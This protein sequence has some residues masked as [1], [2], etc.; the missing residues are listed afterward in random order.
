MRVQN[1]PLC[2]KE[3][4]AV[5]VAE[6]EFAERLLMEG[7]NYEFRCYHASPTIEELFTDFDALQMNAGESYHR[8]DVSPRASFD[9]SSYDEKEYLRQKA[10]EVARRSQIFSDAPFLFAPTHVGY[11]I[12]AIVTGS[13]TDDGCVGAKLL[14]YVAANSSMNTKA[15]L[16]CFCKSVQEVVLYLV[17]CPCMD[18]RPTCGRAGEI[19]AERA[20][21]LRRVLGEVASVRLLRKLESS[22]SGSSVYLKRSRFETDFTPP[23]QV[24]ARTFVRVSPSNGFC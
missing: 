22:R 8:G 23:R 11:A 15:E 16:H 10:L 7:L 13:V 20:E 21:E 9:Y 17:N 5:S 3:L 14:Q 2:C 12:T 4:R 24:Q 6:I 19:I 18:L 1:A